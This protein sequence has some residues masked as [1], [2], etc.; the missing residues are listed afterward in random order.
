MHAWGYYIDCPV[1]LFLG[2][3]LT[4]GIYDWFTR[5][6]LSGLSTYY[7]YSVSVQCLAPFSTRSLCSYV[8]FTLFAVYVP[9]Q[10]DYRY[11]IW[12]HFIIHFLRKVLC[13]TWNLTVFLCLLLLVKEKNAMRAKWHDWI[14]NQF[15]P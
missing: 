1:R 12:L 14:I 13:K 15:I 10:S 4:C 3:T 6:R 9:F 2:N 11:H 5:K 7:V 8:V